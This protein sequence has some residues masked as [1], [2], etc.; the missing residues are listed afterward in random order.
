M[1]KNPPDDQGQLRGLPQNQ[2]LEKTSGGLCAQCRQV[3]ERV[4]AQKKGGFRGIP[5]FSQVVRHE[6]EWPIVARRTGLPSEPESC[7]AV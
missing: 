5:E 3:R 4:N 6:N 1:E 2:K 7:Y